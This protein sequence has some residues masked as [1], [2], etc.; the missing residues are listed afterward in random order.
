M[1]IHLGLLV[2]D[3]VILIV[4]GVCLTLVYNELHEDHDDEE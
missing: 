4:T 1:Q 3:I 2:F